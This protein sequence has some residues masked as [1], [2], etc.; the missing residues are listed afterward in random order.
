MEKINYQE[1]LPESKYLDFE[2]GFGKGL[3][4][5]NYSKNHLGR[6]I[7]GIEIRKP[8]VEEVKKEFE[9]EKIKNVYLLHG[10]AEICLEDTIDDSSLDKIFLF[11]PDPWIKNQHHKRRVIQS[12]FLNILHQKLKDDG[13]L[14][15]STDVENLWIF[16][17]KIIKKSEKFTSISNDNFWQDDYSSHWHIYTTQDN[18]KT[19]FGTFEKK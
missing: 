4:L 8:I 1:S 13:K 3:F 10:K 9:I 11:H 6:N 16:M 7:I 2:I 12:D 14:Y 19:F 5:K 15:V 18:R 17:E